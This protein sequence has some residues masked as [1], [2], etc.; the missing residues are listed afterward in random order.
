MVCRD[1]ISYEY[2]HVPW[3]RYG[4]L[5]AAGIVTASRYSG[6]KH[7]LSD[8]AVGSGIGFLIGRYVY[9]KHHIAPDIDPDGMPSKKST[10]FM[11]VIS[12]FYEP[13]SRTYAANLTWSF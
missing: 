2:K 9:K 1:R 11:P 4:A 3:V 6:R 7:F 12:P 13:G 5:A 8:L 10:T